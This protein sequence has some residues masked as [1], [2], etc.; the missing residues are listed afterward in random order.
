MDICSFVQ[1]FSGEISEQRAECND[2]AGMVARGFGADPNENQEDRNKELEGCA[3]FTGFYEFYQELGDYIEKAKDI[4]KSSNIKWCWCVVYDE[5]DYDKPDKYIYH[6]SFSY[7]GLEDAKKQ[8][9]KVSQ[10]NEPE[11]D[12]SESSIPSYGEWKLK[13]FG[14]IM[15]PESKVDLHVYTD[16][17]TDEIL[18]LG[19]GI[20]GE[21][22]WQ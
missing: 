14:H 21:D 2:L 10:I 20:L 18:I 9:L 1:G 22:S 12:D 5:F 6:G 8:A 4:E 11:C 7:M 17:N 15:R 19:K 13:T 16:I 3:D